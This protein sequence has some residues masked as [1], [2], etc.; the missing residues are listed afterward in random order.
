MDELKIFFEQIQ[1]FT[2]GMRD[3]AAGATEELAKVIEYLDGK[4]AEID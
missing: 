1:R 3:F 4:I 2:N